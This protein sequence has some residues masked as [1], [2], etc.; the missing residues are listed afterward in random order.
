[1]RGIASDF[2][3]FTPR[4][5]RK[6]GRFEEYGQAAFFN[7]HQGRLQVPAAVN[8]RSFRWKLPGLIRLARPT[9][10]RERERRNT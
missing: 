4:S 10:G 5:G 2:T 3:Y 8:G 6:Y 7:E 1:M 9:F